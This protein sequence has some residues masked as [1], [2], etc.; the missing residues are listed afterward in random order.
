[1]LLALSICLFLLSL[2]L[3]YSE[4][5]ENQ[6]FGITLLVTSFT[7]GIVSCYHMVVSKGKLKLLVEY[8]EPVRIAAEKIKE[9]IK[10]VNVYGIESL[11][12]IIEQAMKDKLIDFTEEEIK[13]G[14]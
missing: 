9:I 3:V 7:I 13:K 12:N 8:G 11:H 10:Q 5:I 1:M 4:V 6:N 14:K 2:N